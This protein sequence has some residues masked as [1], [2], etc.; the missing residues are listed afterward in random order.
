[1]GTVDGNEYLTS[2]DYQYDLSGDLRVNIDSFMADASYS[3]RRY[4][5][6]GIIRS[7]TQLASGRPLDVSIGIRTEEDEYLERLG[8]EQ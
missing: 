8:I 2:E 5:D 7:I 6:T 1:M 3:I 4:I